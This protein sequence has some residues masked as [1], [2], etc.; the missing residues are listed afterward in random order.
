MPWALAKRTIGRIRSS[1]HADKT[2]K[3]RGS[4][5][6]DLDYARKRLEEK[7]GRILLCGHTHTAQQEDLGAGYRLIVLPPWCETPAGMVEDGQSFKPFTL[8]QLG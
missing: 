5:A 6:I 4:I 8:E 2:R 7:G 1:T 3:P